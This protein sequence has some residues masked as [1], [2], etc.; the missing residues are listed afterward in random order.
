MDMSDTQPES[1]RPAKRRK[2]YRK[3]A[4][5][6]DGESNEVTRPSHSPSHL[7]PAQALQDP[8]DDVA[9]PPPI[10]ADDQSTV[11]VAD[12]LR[13]RKA[14]QRRRGG[15]EFTSAAS[16]A[17]PAPQPSTALIELEERQDVPA[18]IKAVISRFAPQTGQVTEE[19]DK[20][21][22]AYIEAELAKR[23]TRSQHDPS[24]SSAVSL[25]P[26]D[27]DAAEDG[28]SAPQRQ[29]AA[30]GKLHEI[31][32]GPDSKL[33]N[34]KRTEAA[35]SGTATSDVPPPKPPRPRIGRNGKPYIPKP[36]KRRN[37]ADMARDKVVEE[38]LRETRLDLYDEPEAGG[39][40]GAAGDEEK[41]AAD[42]RIAEEFRR[43]FLDAISQRRKRSSKPPAAGA[44]RVGGKAVEE[45]PRGPKLGGSRSAR[46]AMRERE[47]AAAKAS[48]KGGIRR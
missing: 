8:T 7:S 11:S 9:S 3:R 10:Q 45:K 33:R 27:D 40:S 21:M 36:R 39:K 30:L 26:Y 32:L 16:N 13:L 25:Q 28:F 22:M 24:T 31:D 23:A 42:D 20:H 48:G 12:L 4:T 44:S 18:D 29:P 17:S 14:A 15:V 37:S 34:I 46:A 38:L 2:F 5:S 19:A 41:E 35:I 43:D 1:S 47:E 6:E